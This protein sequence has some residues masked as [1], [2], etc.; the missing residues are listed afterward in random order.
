MDF[1]E[2]KQT[3]TQREFA[4]TTKRVL[5]N[6]HDWFVRLR[7]HDLACN[8]R[9]LRELCAGLL[10]LGNVQVHL[11]TIKVGVVRRRDT[12]VETESRVV[13]EFDAMR[14]HT[15]L[16]QRRLTVKEHIVTIAQVTFDNPSNLQCNVTTPVVLEINTLSR[17]TNDVS[18]AGVFVRTITNQ[19]GEVCT[20]KWRHTLG[21]CE[22]SGN[23]LGHTNLV[24]L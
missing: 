20:I 18:C 1:L 23:T 5:Y 4:D 19:L 16:V 11:I 8:P 24:E 9:D 6:T 2:V 14:H 12:E 10:T 21:V 3:V 13:H 7:R 17:V 22:I 15:H